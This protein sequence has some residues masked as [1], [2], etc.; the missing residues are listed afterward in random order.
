MYTLGI[1]GYQPVDVHCKEYNWSVF[2]DL[3]L[4]GNV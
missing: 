4:V 1:S 3:P 2:I